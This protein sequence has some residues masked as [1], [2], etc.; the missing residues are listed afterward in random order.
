MTVA[1]CGF[2]ASG[3]SWFGALAARRCGLPFRDLDDIVAEMG[4]APDASALIEKIGIAEFRKLESRALASA[5]EGGGEGI[6]ALG[7]GSVLDVENR[8]MLRR[9]AYVIWL[10]TAPHLIERWMGSSPRPLAGDGRRESWGPLWVERR[11]I[12]EVLCN[13]RFPI[14]DGDEPLIVER[15][16]AAIQRALAGAI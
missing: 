9:N 12:Y 6:L 7:G 14:E 8:E 4:G 10:D 1:L 11:A 5:L 16:A 2:M 13:E 15:L 3:K